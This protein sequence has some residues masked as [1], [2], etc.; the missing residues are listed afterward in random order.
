MF[1]YSKWRLKLRRVSPRSEPFLRKYR[2]AA[3]EAIKAPTVELKM[4]LAAWNEALHSGVTLRREPTFEEKEA[5]EAL[6]TVT[7]YRYFADYG[8]YLGEHCHALRERATRIKEGAPKVEGIM[9]G[10]WQSI[11]KDLE[12]EDESVEKWRK[13]NLFRIV[14]ESPYPHTPKTNA[15]IR[16]CQETDYNEENARYSI[17][18]YGKRNQIMHSNVSQYIKDLKFDFLALQVGRDLKEVT[19]VFGK[20]NFGSFI[21]LCR[22]KIEI[23]S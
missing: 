19:S 16:T 8:D 15:L 14:N 5:Y 2:E 23:V 13:E 12:K 3:E 7:M 9:Q 4:K 17:K 10:T 11:Q 18:M 20:W 22:S 1:D 6:E 21:F